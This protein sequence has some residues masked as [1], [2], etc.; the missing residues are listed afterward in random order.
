MTDRI[1]TADDVRALLREAVKAAGGQTAWGAA[2]GMSQAHV[3]I[4]LSGVRP[5]NE[6]VAAAFGLEKF[7]AWRKT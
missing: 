1:Y 6:R 7:T 2:H 4:M 5:P 3:A